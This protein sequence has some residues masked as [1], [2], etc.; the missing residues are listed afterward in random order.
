MK[1]NQKRDDMQRQLTELNIELQTTVAK[2]DRLRAEI[3]VSERIEKE[4][5]IPILTDDHLAQM[6]LEFE[7]EGMGYTDKSRKLAL[8]ANFSIVNWS[9]VSLE[10]LEAMN[11]IL[12]D[13]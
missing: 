8:I 3:N 4:N 13:D 9:Y 5:N 2:I 10:A 1:S 11:N 7:S 12:I 6:M